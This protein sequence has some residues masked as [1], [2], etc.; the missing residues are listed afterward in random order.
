MKKSF[1]LGLERTGVGT[2]RAIT[3]SLES[4]PLW[5]GVGS[6]PGVREHYP[7]SLAW[8]PRGFIRQVSPGDV[9]RSVVESYANEAYSYIT[10][11]PGASAWANRLAEDCIGF[12]RRTYGSLSGKRVLDIGAGSRY[13]GD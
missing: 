11:P 5:K 10:A 12:I 8:D 1:G 3:V 4:L 9:K 7:F 6:R 13:V 2:H